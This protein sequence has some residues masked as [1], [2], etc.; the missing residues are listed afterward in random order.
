MN[1]TIK[2]ITVCFKDETVNIALNSNGNIDL[3]SLKV[4]FEDAIGL[5]Y[6]DEKDL[7]LTCPMTN[8]EIKIKSLNEVYNVRIS[9]SKS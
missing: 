2:E 3:N 7:V 4:Y 9:K 6:L 1:Q 8:N 5:T